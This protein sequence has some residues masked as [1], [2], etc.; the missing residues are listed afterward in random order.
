MLNLSYYFGG[1]AMT[2]LKDTPTQTT[3][4]TH[5]KAYQK[6]KSLAKAPFDLTKEGN[7]NPQRLSKF[8]AEAAGYRFIY[9]TERITEET[10]TA[11]HELAIETGALHK[12]ERMQ[13]GDVMNFIEGFPC[14]NRETLHTAVRD[15]FDH[16]NTSKRAIE[17]AKMARAET[18]KLKQFLNKVDK[19]KKY[20]NLIVIAIGG[21]DL[22]PRA[23]YEGLK[24]LQREDRHVHFVGN[25]DPDTAAAALKN[26]DL[27][28]SLV[29]VVSK[30]GT[31]LET[32][33]NEE[34]VKSYFT[35]AGL[36]PEEHFIAIT[37]EGSPM[38][39][40]TKYLEVFH[41]WDWVG[42]RFSASSVIGGFL[43]A[44]ACG[45][46]TYWEYLR[47]AHA[48]DLSALSKDLNSNLPLLGALLGIWNRN[49]LGLQ[50]LAVVP[51]SQ[52]L[53]RYAAHIQQVDMESNGKQIDQQGHYIDFETG[54][55]VFGEPGTSAQHS[56]YQLIHQGT[57]PVPLELIGYKESTIGKDNTY[58][59]TTLQEKL[60]A[61]LFAQAIA[62]ATGHPDTNPN[63]SFPGNRPSHLLLAKQL[64]PF[65]LGALLAYFEH[66]VVFQGFIWGINSFDQEG[67]QL[68][69]VLANKIIGRFADQHG[70]GTSESYP[71]G[72]A[73]LAHL[74]T[75]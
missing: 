12:M 74:K 59:G 41:L 27:K 72:D 65:S 36:K 20:T 39:D 23:Q 68:G 60:L 10:M 31:T 17:A 16:P 32:K 58:N 48:M 45:F 43:I 34:F 42:G 15:F 2:L 38:D 24:H 54:P 67:V 33:S 5:R 71:L 14:E 4:F 28:K 1:K 3:T 47:G 19:E 69:K 21:S 75:L 7:L 46:D 40:K 37:S 44:F 62:L 55:I 13:A 56:F 25:I 35:K 66:K 64:T 73:Y 52:A 18:E 22:G 29:A 30:T 53:H 70:K 50:T 9:G 8:V 11:L 51:Y 26:V 6:L 57:T 61:N 49:F 63:K